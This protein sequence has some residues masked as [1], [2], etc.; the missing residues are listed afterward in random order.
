MEDTKKKVHETVEE[1]EDIT[2]EE[3]LK[4]S[5]IAHLTPGQI[6]E[7]VFVRKSPEGYLFDIGHKREAVVSG[8]E[9]IPREI[10]SAP[11]KL[12]VVHPYSAAHGGNPLLSWAEVFR[13]E[14]SLNLKNSFDSKTPVEGAIL[15][16]TKGGYMV[17]LGGGAEAFMPGAHALRKNDKP[18]GR[19]FSCLVIEMKGGNIVVSE[20]LAADIVREKAAQEIFSKHTVGDE[21]DGTVVSLAKFGAFVDIGGI[22]ALVHVSDISWGGGGKMNEHIKVGQKVSA[23]ILSMDA[24]TKKISLGIKQ[25]SGDPWKK[26]GEKYSV[27]STVDCVTGNTT[28]FGVFCAIEPGVDGLLHISEVD[29]QNPNPDLA[30]LFPKGSK[31]KA[32]IISIDA[33]KNK[34]SLSLRRLS[35][36]PWEKAAEGIKAGN[37][38]SGIVMRVTPFGAVVKVGGALEGTLHVKNLDWFKKVSNPSTMLKTGQEIKLRVLEFDPQQQRLE[39]SLKH[40]RGNPF[41]KYKKK[42]VLDCAAV[43]VTPAGVVVEIEPGV[44]G[45][46]PRNEITRKKGDEVSE[47]IKP[48]D[49][50]RGVVME[51]DATRRRIEISVKKFEIEQE[52]KLLAKYSAKKP[53]PSLNDLL[54]EI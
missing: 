41:E 38:V 31:I 19:K 46:V 11:L 39:L 23:K 36:S 30:K 10:L 2:M 5:D 35:A 24:A 43:T 27:G 29:W 37:E 7:G 32:K 54:D 42:T 9:A 47:L 8:N 13:K 17:D 6:V 20:R 53:G 16:A 18:S 40:L 15:R 50:L 33:A 44:E 12:K 48:G 4:E 14:A 1:T 21:V 25:M 45:F 22:D 28:K 51:S 34:I 3:L 26:V 52:K 49:K